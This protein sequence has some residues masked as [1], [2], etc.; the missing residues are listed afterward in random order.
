MPQEFAAKEIESLIRTCMDNR[1]RRFDCKQFSL[2]LR[3]PNEVVE[4][5]LDAAAVEFVGPSPKRSPSEEEKRRV[6]EAEGK[7]LDTW[8]NQPAPSP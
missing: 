4:D 7:K 8:F 3:T 6:I 1:V 5:T 2:D